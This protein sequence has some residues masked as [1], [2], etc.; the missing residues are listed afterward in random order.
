MLSMIWM[1]DILL[2]PSFFVL[3]SFLFAGMLDDGYLQLVSY[4]TI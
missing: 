1:S 4:D 2:F 3:I